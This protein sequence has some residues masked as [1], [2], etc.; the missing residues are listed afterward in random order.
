[1]CARYQRFHPVA[2]DP[3]SPDDNVVYRRLEQLHK[4]VVNAAP[5]RSTLAQQSRPALSK[6]PAG[7]VVAARSRSQSWKRCWRSTPSSNVTSFEPQESAMTRLPTS[8]DPVNTILRMS[9]GDEPLPTTV[10]FPGNTCRFVQTRL[11][12]LAHRSQYRGQRRQLAGLPA[13]RCWRPAPAR[14]PRTRSPS[15]IPRRDHT[16]HAHRFVER[17][18]PCRN[19]NSACR[20]TVPL[21]A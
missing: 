7:A 17:R 9:V 1:M 13:P 21:A 5:H 6:T 8:V 4:P 2:R 18:P 10:P 14:W 12:V 19:G 11:D 3:G 20:T 16:D 15:G